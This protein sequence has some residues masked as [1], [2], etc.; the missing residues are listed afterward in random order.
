MV[1]RGPAP[2]LAE[3]SPGNAMVFSWQEKW[4]ERKRCNGVGRALGQHQQSPDPYGYRE[5]FKGGGQRFVQYQR[6]KRGL[7]EHPKF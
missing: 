6:L 3:A 2:G 7:L 1:A 5:F 4:C